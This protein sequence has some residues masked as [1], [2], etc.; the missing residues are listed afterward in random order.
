M[1]RFSRA[2]ALSSLALV[3]SACTPERDIALTPAPGSQPITD[4]SPYICKL[5]PMQAFLMVSGIKTPLIDKMS[6][7]LANGECRAA[8]IPPPPLQVNWIEADNRHGQEQ[9]DFLMEDRRSTYKRHDGVK[10]PAEL[11]DGMAAHVTNSPLADQPYRISAKFRCGGVERMV[12]IFLAE[13]AEGRDGIKDLIELM[14]I[15][16]KRYGD[17]HGC[18]LGA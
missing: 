10:I 9:L 6:G 5:V 18:V 2:A 11:G 1:K 15:A 4:S 3:I 16:Q 12:D 17:L 14:R 7:S 13:V 8:D